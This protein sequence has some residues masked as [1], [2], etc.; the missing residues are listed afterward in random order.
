MDKAGGSSR[1]TWAGH[2]W[3]HEKDM[4]R[5]GLVVGRCKTRL[6]TR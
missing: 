2:V 6:D 4:S 1:S 3:K 5:E